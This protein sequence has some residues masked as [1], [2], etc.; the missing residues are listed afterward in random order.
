MENKKGVVLVCDRAPERDYIDLFTDNLEFTSGVYFDAINAALLN[1][2]RRYT[3][4]ET[5]EEF[6]NNI[7]QHKED[8]VL[9]AVWSGTLSRNRKSLLPA[10]CEAYNIDYVGADAYAQTICQDKHL[11]KIFCQKFDIEIPRGYQFASTD[12]LEKIR[13]LNFP[14]IVKPN[15]EGSSIGISDNSIA[16]DYESA[17][18]L[19]LKLIK[20]FNPVLV[21]EYVDG[22]EV[23]ICC[24]GR[25]D[26]S[27]CEAVGLVVNGKDYFTHQIWGYESKKWD[28]AIVSRKNVSHLVGENILHEAKRIFCALGKV[29]YMRIDGRFKDGKF[30]LIELTPDCSLHP[31]CFM[32]NAFYANDL[33]YD[34]MINTLLA[35]YD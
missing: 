19:V 31:A 10:V 4:Y 18:Q 26:V 11:S 21:E 34:D 7:A 29:D 15:G 3:L 12:C 27:V 23:S 14:V 28:K 22:M 2:G 25:N 24:V 35:L 16:D 17:K 9:S 1:T 6:I 8:I 20:K 5:P 13:N 30:Y 33:S 32:A